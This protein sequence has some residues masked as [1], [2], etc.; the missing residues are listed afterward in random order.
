VSPARGAG[1]VWA[2]GGVELRGVWRREELGVFL[3][4]MSVR[5]GCRAAEAAGTRFGS[6]GRLGAAPRMTRARSGEGRPA[7]QASESLCTAV[8]AVPSGAR[9]A[10]LGSPRPAGTG[11]AGP[12]EVVPARGP[13][14]LRAAGRGGGTGAGPG[15]GGGLSR[16]P[17]GAGR[18]LVFRHCSVHTSCSP[19][20]PF[21]PLCPGRGEAPPLQ[22]VWKSGGRRE[23]GGKPLMCAELGP[24][25]R[26]GAAPFFTP[27][28][29]CHPFSLPRR[30]P[31]PTAAHALESRRRDLA[32]HSCFTARVF[33]FS[34]GGGGS[35]SVQRNDTDFLPPQL[36]GE[37][38]GGEGRGGEDGGYFFPGSWVLFRLSSSEC[39]SHVAGPS[40]E[41]GEVRWRR[42]R[43]RL[44][45]WPGAL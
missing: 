5:E 2:P 6:P 4:V 23:L 14:Q 31:V 43:L 1:R 39:D 36:G 16:R 18:D 41:C 19:P 7:P 11:P 37:G 30:T 3:E 32:L 27:H 20:L 17:V 12:R 34:P 35:L 26:L 13:P 28:P 40:A 29:A 9:R 33:L 10:G 24:P 15:C 22:P 8:V 45:W 25:L 44:P 38:R 42:W 21:C